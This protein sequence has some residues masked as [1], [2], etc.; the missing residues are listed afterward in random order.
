MEIVS[1]MV[2]GSSRDTPAPTETPEALIGHF[3]TKLALCRKRGA[4]INQL[5]MLAQD[6]LFRCLPDSEVFMAFMKIGTTTGA[7][8]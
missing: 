1:H 7:R 8:D 5:L 3:L 4:E 6:A 2:F